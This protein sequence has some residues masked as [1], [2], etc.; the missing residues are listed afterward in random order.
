[1]QGDPGPPG[2]IG[3]QGSIGPPGVIGFPQGP[4]VRLNAIVLTEF[5]TSK[6]MK[7]R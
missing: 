3:Q 5:T 7:H 2:P 6:G 1:M 4:K